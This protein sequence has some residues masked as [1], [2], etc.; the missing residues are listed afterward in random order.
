MYTIYDVR[1]AYEKALKRFDEE[2]GDR[3]GY[4]D[5]LDDRISDAFCDC[6][7]EIESAADECIDWILECRKNEA[8]K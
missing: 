8:E 3:C 5:W 7:R 4:E 1:E 6:V 2:L